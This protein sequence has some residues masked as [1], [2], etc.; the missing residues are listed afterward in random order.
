MYGIKIEPKSDISI[1]RQICCQLRKLM[2]SGKLKSGVQLPPTRKFAS[3]LN[4]S[5]NTIVEVY[6]QLSAE[7]Y[8][9]SRVGSGTFVSSGIC[10]NIAKAEN[11]NDSVTPSV[12]SQLSNQDIIDF[13]P[14]IPDLSLVP[15]NLWGKYL[16]QASDNSYSI[17]NN[18]SNVMGDSDLRNIL[19]EYVFRVKGIR[20]HPEQIMIVSGSSQ[21]FL[22]IAQAL[23]RSYNQIYIEDPTVNFT[24]NIFKQLHYKINPVPVDDNGMNIS[25]SKF[26]LNPSLFLLT[27]SHQLPTGN[28][29]SIQRR[30]QAI[31]IVEKT[32]G[33]I[34]E[35]DYDSEFRFKGIPIP[36]LQVLSPSK[37]I[38]VGTF[39]KTLFPGIRLG[40][41]ILPN[42]LVKL[43]KYTK[44]SM[45][46]YTPIIDQIALAN[47]IRD[48][49]LDRHIYKMK[50]IYK[51]RR[52]LLVNCLHKYFNDKIRILGDAAGMHI[53]VEFKENGF[54]KIDWGNALEYN[55][56]VESMEEYSILKN[57]NRNK[58][59]LGYGNIDDLH[60]KEGIKRLY[61]FVND[62][63]S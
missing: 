44:D 10:M 31:E 56:I 61:E 40:F 33:Y 34:I 14:G 12:A 8:L 49:H 38:Y 5:R 60:I 19:S 2:E 20:C 52:D 22:L 11:S 23:L 51:K 54:P 37:V 59:V 9:E 57:S 55:I 30:L 27:P 62:S 41:I 18:F 35:D 28:V 45:C 47:F 13:T 6:E 43:L 48:G 3:E 50:T 17:Q 53:Q 32:G 25:L 58:I 29:L 16:R 4:V 46:M 24:R 15:T 26:P 36:P 1:T 7:G 21:G 63:I 39:S 42:R